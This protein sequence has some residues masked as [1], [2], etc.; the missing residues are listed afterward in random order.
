MGKLEIALEKLVAAEDL[1]LGHPLSE[2]KDGDKDILVFEDELLWTKAKVPF[3]LPSQFGP[4]GRCSAA[5]DVPR[6]QAIPPPTLEEDID[7][8][9]FLRWKSLRQ[10]CKIVQVVKP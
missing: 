3:S 10:L 2:P 8:R 7:L 6:I 5:A 4:A 9:G 1:V